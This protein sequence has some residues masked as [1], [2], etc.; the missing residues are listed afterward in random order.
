MLFWLVLHSFQLSG[1]EATEAGF[2]GEKWTSSWLI[3]SPTNSMKF[4]MR[5]YFG[6]SLEEPKGGPEG[7]H[8]GYIRVLDATSP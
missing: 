7:T 4:D 5:K 3:R 1:A 2:S 6:E 8:H